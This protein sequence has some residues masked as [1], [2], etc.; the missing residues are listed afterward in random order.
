MN[1]TYDQGFWVFE[2]HIAARNAGAIKTESKSSFAHQTIKLMLLLVILGFGSSMAQE[3]LYFGVGLGGTVTLVPYPDF[4]FQ[5]GAN[6]S[7]N[8]EFRFAADSIITFNNFALDW[9]Y[10]DAP[11]EGLA[12]YMGGGPTVLLVVIP[13]EEPITL[14]GVGAHVTAGLEQPLGP[15]SLYAELQAGSTIFPLPI[16]FAKLRAGL[17]FYL[18]N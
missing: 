18:P 3:D 9:L 2:K 17:N 1:K 15:V 7:D 13:L 14:F 4:G 16:P 6:L 5:V 8:L 11:D 10:E 12:F